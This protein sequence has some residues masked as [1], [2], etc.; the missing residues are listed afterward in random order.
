M[1]KKTD[2]VATPVAPVAAVSTRKMTPKVTNVVKRMTPEEQEVWFNENCAKLDAETQKTIRAKMTQ[3]LTVRK[4]NGEKSKGMDYN[5]EWV[6][7]LTLM[8]VLS[9]KFLIDKNIPSRDEEKNKARED[10]KAQM[11]ALKAQEAALV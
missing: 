2:T 3:P 11:E 4:A 7:S 1:A 9:I 8:Q 5:A 6:A 10:L